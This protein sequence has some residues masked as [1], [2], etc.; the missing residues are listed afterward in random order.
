M[1]SLAAHHAVG[2]IRRLFRRGSLGA[3]LG[4]LLE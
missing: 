1:Q 4:V 2:L 3:A